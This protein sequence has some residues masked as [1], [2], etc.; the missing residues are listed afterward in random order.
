[1]TPSTNPPKLQIH[2]SAKRYG[3]FFCLL[4]T[5]LV[6]VAL[7]TR[8]L[9]WQPPW[10]YYGLLLTTAAVLLLLGIAK[11]LE[12]PT[13]LLITLHD[14]TFIH[15]RGQLRLRWDNI[16]RLDIPKVPEGL[17]EHELPYLGIRLAQDEELLDHISPRLAAYF[18]HNQRHILAIAM[19]RVLPPQA[20]YTAYFDVPERY[21]SRAGKSYHGVLAM[22]GL[23]TAQLREL[24]G[25][26]VYLPANALDRPLAEFVEYARELNRTRHQQETP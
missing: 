12:P 25:Y 14:I 16:V 10:G 2:P 5:L 20:D 8:L 1:M 17:S 18:I 23:R 6:L 24:L 9:D 26:D 22:F 3:L 15:R 13:S 21:V 11:L 4:G 7:L 19:R